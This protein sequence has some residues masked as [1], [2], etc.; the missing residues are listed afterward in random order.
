MGQFN[1]LELREL[2]RKRKSPEAFLKAA[3][4]SISDTSLSWEERQ[5]IWHFLWKSGFHKTLAET[6]AK[7]LRA[8]LKTPLALIVQT[9]SVYKIEFTSLALGAL[10]KGVIKQDA[11]DELGSTVKWEDLSEPL[12][13]MRRDYLYGLTQKEHELKAGLIE[14]F[15]FLLSQRMQEQALRVLDRLIDTYPED[16]EF[17]VRKAGMKEQWARDVILDRSSNR[18]SHLDDVERT[19]TEKSIGDL[20]MLEAFA[21]ESAK[22]FLDDREFAQ[23]F[24]ICMLFVGEYQM[25]LEALVW[26]EESPSKDWLKAELLFMGRRYVELLDWLHQLEIKFCQDPETTFAA[27]YLRARA[28]KALGQRHAAIEILKSIVHIRPHYRSAHALILEWAEGD[29]WD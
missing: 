14:K 12:K 23:S 6:M 5:P 9:C 15:E 18:R 4:K 17:K 2:L 20:A 13:K 29:L 25:A 27:N 10:Q 22:I 26:A 7:S 3:L 11:F 19:Q 1:E 8:K 28:I 24:A 21:L 16:T